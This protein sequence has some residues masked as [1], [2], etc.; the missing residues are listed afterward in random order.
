M[1]KS[2][3]SPLVCTVVRGALLWIKRRCFVDPIAVKTSGLMGVK[4]TASARIRG[5]G[6]ASLRGY[7]PVCVCVP[8]CCIMDVWRRVFERR[9]AGSSV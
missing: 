9:P 6:V 3:Q 7:D 8:V 5:R 4:A 2:G 1:I